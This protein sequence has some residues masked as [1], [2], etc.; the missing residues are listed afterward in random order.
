[1]V[2]VVAGKKIHLLKKNILINI[3]RFLR[4]NIPAYLSVPVFNRVP[5]QF[6]LQSTILSLFFFLQT[7]PIPFLRICI[8][9]CRFEIAH[10]CSLCF[11]FSKPRL[12]PPP[13]CKVTY[14]HIYPLFSRLIYH[15]SSFGVVYAI[16]PIPSIHRTQYIDRDLPDPYPLL[17]SIM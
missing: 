11:F 13:P 1:M 8:P 12:P 6:M 14:I 5:H 2:Q 4:R 16:P 7:Y 10:S 15:P 9:K 17:T 3:L